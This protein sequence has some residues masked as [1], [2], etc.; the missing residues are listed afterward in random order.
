[1]TKA[2]IPAGAPGLAESEQITVDELRLAARNHGMPL[3]ALRHPITPL[4]LH[5]LLIHYDIP[6]VEPSTWRLSVGGRVV[7]PLSLTLDELRRRPARTLP[8]TMECAGNGRAGLHPRPVSQP[9]LLEA[10]GNASWTGTPL[11]PLLKEAGVGSDAVEV[12]FTGLDRGVEGGVEQAYERALPVEEALGDDVLLA[13]EVNGGPLPPQHGFPLRLLVPGWY[14]MASVKWLVGITAV[15]EPFRGYQN[16]EGYR[17]QSGPDDEG[18]PVTRIAPRSL[19]VPPGIPDFATRRR[20]LDAGP[21]RLQGR[22]WSGWA[23]VKRVEVSTDG[24]ATWSEAELAPS[25]GPWAWRGWWYD[26]EPS[27]PGQHELCSRARDAA[28]NE[29]PLEPPWNLKGYSNNAVQRV[30]V[31]V[32]EP[33]RS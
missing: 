7:R 10:V 33:R 4:G 5:Y 31:T 30:E 21:C 14:G 29:Q 2:T 15:A 1:M 27:D 25:A 16:A 6:L 32:R 18:H 11:G 28:G 23:E 8:V 26:W 12:V 17:F 9:W 22:A 24:G 13:Y 20:F 19:M 3:E